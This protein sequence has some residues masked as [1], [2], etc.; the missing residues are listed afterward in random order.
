MSDTIELSKDHF[1][2]SVATFGDRLEAARLAKGL[3]IE[4]LAEKLAFTPEGVQAWEN[5]ETSPRA[6]RIQLLAGLLNVS[7]VW[8]I[9]G[10]GNGTSQVADTHQRPEGVND[11]LGEIAQLKETLSGAL[12]K[13]TKLENRLKDID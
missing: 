4:G 9:S 6:N 11:A 8:L 10:E 5:D 1:N 7:L 3:T 12:D 2:E 13:L